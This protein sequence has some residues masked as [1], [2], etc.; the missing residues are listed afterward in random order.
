M[1]I[2]CINN[3]NAKNP[4]SWMKIG[5]K[6]LVLDISTNIIRQ[7]I[8][9]H[10]LDTDYIYSS[11]VVPWD[12]FKVICNKMPSNWVFKYDEDI[13]YGKRIFLAPNNWL[14][15]EPWTY[16]FWE[17]LHCAYDKYYEAITEEEEEERARQV[18]LEESRKIYEECGKG[19]VPNPFE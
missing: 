8:S 19:W 18:F 13:N 12:N 17:S 14:D 2:E 1:I 4:L 11:S 7:E 15:D 9:Y 16:T 3:L 6:F 5:Q 10:V